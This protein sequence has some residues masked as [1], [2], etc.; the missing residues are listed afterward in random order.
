ML[1][2]SWLRSSEIIRDIVNEIISACKF[3][4]SLSALP[5]KTAKRI[6]SAAFSFS[7]STIIVNNNISINATGR[8][9][10][11]FRAAI[12]ANCRDLK[13]L[14]AH[15]RIFFYDRGIY[16]CAR[17]LLCTCRSAFVPLANWNIV[18]I[19]RIYAALRGSWSGIKRNAETT[20]RVVQLYNLDSR[21]RNLPCRTQKNAELMQTRRAI[22]T[23]NSSMKANLNKLMWLSN[24]IERKRMISEI[25]SYRSI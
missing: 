5:S 23:N 15:K 9:T 25:R 4:L 16:D 19:T 2:L 17:F 22:Y 11:Y 1:L 8:H 7:F 13:P 20:N 24:L 14:S 12:P 10:S 6:F 3:N 18:P 21:F